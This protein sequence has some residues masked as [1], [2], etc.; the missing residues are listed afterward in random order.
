VRV[1][2]GDLDEAAERDGRDLIDR[3]AALERDERRAEAD[4][5][6]LHAHPAEASHQEVP[7][8]MQHDEEGQA[9]D[10]H[11]DRQRRHQ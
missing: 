10:G 8:F 5:E 2:A 9:E 7:A 11:R 6:A 4:G 1:E 3:V